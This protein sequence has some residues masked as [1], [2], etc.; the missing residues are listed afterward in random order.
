[1]LIAIFVALFGNGMI[2]IHSANASSMDHESAMDSS[3]N[4]MC[5]GNGCMQ[6][7]GT[8][9][10]HCVST[11]IENKQTPATTANQIVDVS[12]DSISPDFTIPIRGPTQKHKSQNLKPTSTLQLIKSVMKKE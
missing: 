5:S 6:E 2:V 11:P 3:Q 12:N 10:T 4:A 1:L 7:H 8:C 9:E